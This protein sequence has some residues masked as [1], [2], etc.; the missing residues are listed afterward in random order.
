MKIIVI[1]SPRTAST[2]YCEQLANKYN[3]LNHNEQLTSNTHYS[4]NYSQSH[5]K[6]INDELVSKTQG[7]YKIHLHQFLLNKDFIDYPNKIKQLEFLC[8][9][10]DEIHYLWR[11][12]KIAQL[13]SGLIANRTG[14]FEDKE[15]TNII[16]I[17][18]SKQEYDKGI[19]RLWEHM[20]CILDWYYKY[21]G[22][23][24]YTEDIIKE[25]YKPYRQQYNFNVV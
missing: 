15:P 12:D 4:K 10:A 17:D 14:N 11:K 24:V 16:D 21:P 3:I 25:N 8:S 9:D 5:V 20:N 7:V 6:S 22:K 2:F 18:I 1:T 13:K 19:K 23:N